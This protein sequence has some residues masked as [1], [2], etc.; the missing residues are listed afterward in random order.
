MPNSKIALN[1]QKIETVSNFANTNGLEF[2]NTLS[3]DTENKVSNDPKIF[4]TTKDYNQFSN[5]KMLPSLIL[6]NFFNAATAAGAVLLNIPVSPMFCHFEDADTSRY[7]FPTHLANYAGMFRY[8][9][10]SIKFAIFFTTNMFTSARVRVCY[11][12]NG[13]E[14]TLPTLSDGDFYQKVVDV[15][16]DTVTTFTVPWTKNRPYAE[17]PELYDASLSSTFQKDNYNGRLL[18]QLINPVSAGTVTTDG[19]IYYHIYVS[20][21]SS[22]ECFK[23]IS[24]NQNYSDGYTSTFKRASMRGNM[25]K[26]VT[27]QTKGESSMPQSIHPFVPRDLF[28]LEFEPLAEA[29][30]THFSG[31]CMGEHIPS[32]TALNHRYTYWGQYSNS[33]PFTFNLSITDPDVL[34]NGTSMFY[35]MLRTFH[36]FRGAYKTKF[37][38]FSETPDEENVPSYAIISNKNYDTIFDGTDGVDIVQLSTRTTLE[39]IVPFYYPLVMQCQEG[40]LTDNSALFPTIIVTTNDENKALAYTNFQLYI[41]TADDFSVGYPLVPPKLKLSLGIVHKRQQQN[42]KKKTVI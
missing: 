10:G 5:Y 11:L 41:A 26:S 16:G 14:T 17:V 38:F 7:F 25:K 1:R 4:G 32:W 39:N 27:S 20:G 21:G 8:W 18:L 34:Q 22:F 28:K 15:M 35:R 36:F 9:R 30:E 29:N 3:L 40:I 33:E 13:E 19:N 23:P 31:L 6:Y 2:C 24:L 37:I 42:Q 12:P